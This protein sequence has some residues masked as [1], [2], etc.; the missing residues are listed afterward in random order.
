MA[1]N[2]DEALSNIDEHITNIKTEVSTK[3]NK[4]LLIATVSAALLKAEL[5]H[6]DYR[7]EEAFNVLRTEIL[8]Q[9][10]QLPRELQIVIAQNRMEVEFS[11]SDTN[12]YQQYLRAHD[13]A[14]I[15][16]T[17]L[18]NPE[19]VVD[20]Y[21]SIIANRHYD[22]LPAFL[23]EFKEA[24]KTGSWN[25]Y[26]QAAR[27]LAGEWLQLGRPDIAVYYAIIAHNKELI[28]SVGESLI[29]G[30]SAELIRA[31]INKLLAV[32]N[33]KTHAYSASQ[34]LKIVSDVIP[35]E[36]VD[37]V[38]DWLIN[39]C[40]LAL[41]DFNDFWLS[42]A[43]WEA[44]ERISMR[45]T[46]EQGQKVI[47]I[48]TAHQ[49][50]D[51]PNRLRE[52][53]I[54]AVDACIDYLPKEELVDLAEKSLPA[55]IEKEEL[56][57]EKEALILLC[58]IAE[59]SEEAKRIIGDKLYTD[60]QT[61]NLYLQALSQSFNRQFAPGETDKFAENIVKDLTLQVQRLKPGQTPA[62][63]MVKM[64]TFAARNDQ[65]E[66][67]I[68]IAS[69]LAL[70]ALLANKKQLNA[71][72]IKNLIVTI[73]SM[74][75]EPNNIPS[76]KIMLL[77]G[78]A[79]IAD[80]L[81]SESIEEIYRTLSPVASGKDLSQ[82]KLL[83]SIR[84]SKDPLNPYK[85]NFQTPEEVQAAAIRT[86]ANIE[87]AN[88]GAYGTNLNLIIEKGMVHWNPEI[89]KGAYMASINLL[90]LSETI[91]SN[92]I[93]GTR[94]PDV[95]AAQQAYVTLAFNKKIRLNENNWG[96]IVTAL[97]LGIYSISISVRQIISHL[98]S[99]RRDEWVTSIFAD[100]ISEIEEQL[101][102]DISYSVRKI[103]SAHKKSLEENA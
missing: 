75:S 35:D 91:I 62:E 93:L 47:Y 9:I 21:E 54:K 50:W 31:L 29:A 34:L 55:A 38:F 96:A 1:G 59:R 98:I 2:L 33:L 95:D 51:E 40:K 25:L 41:A 13:E 49:F 60:S 100:R 23:R 57:D 46:A 101:K 32:S 4:S 30:G 28:Q 6:L 20:A 71:A 103:I 24:Y 56:I 86:L 11:Y 81:D 37:S 76:N 45:L 64:A 88:P 80:C 77:S 43:A 85:I 16:G 66:V 83:A 5:L 63:T 61:N 78:L 36:Q 44:V 99:E 74:I 79:N 18:W 7:N 73:L 27:R 102:K 22:A 70:N 17:K 58:D 90:D 65:E 26:R 42:V 48:A 14:E 53:L 10:N 52:Y 84:D 68:Q 15:I 67:V 92:L 87:R 69:P 12:N 89:R 97:S 82:S 8:T 19:N 94:D 72:S 39:I 3:S